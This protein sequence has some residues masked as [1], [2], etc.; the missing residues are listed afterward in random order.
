MKQFK[1]LNPVT[2]FNKQGVLPTGR[3]KKLDSKI[4]YEPIHFGI[5]ANNVLFVRIIAENFWKINHSQIRIEI[6]QWF[7]NSHLFQQNIYWIQQWVPQ[8]SCNGH[9][10]VCFI[11]WSWVSY[12]RSWF[13]FTFLFW[14]ALKQVIESISLG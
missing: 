4:F 12:G 1:T 3:K 8:S 5:K 6:F 10:L 14:S 9:F 7:K 13:S 11:N 2:V